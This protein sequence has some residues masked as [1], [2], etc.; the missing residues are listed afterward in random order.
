MEHERRRDDDYSPLGV[1]A[2]MYQLRSK[3]QDALLIWRRMRGE[4][5]DKL[6]TE[7]KPSPLRKGAPPF[8]PELSDDSG[9]SGSLWE[10]FPAFE[11]YVDR[12]CEEGRKLELEYDR[13]F[14]NLPSS[15]LQSEPE[16][17]CHSSY[18]ESRREIQ[19]DKPKSKSVMWADRVDTEME[20][21]IDD[22]YKTCSY[23][24][25][26][27]S[28]WH[29]EAIDTEGVEK[30]GDL[31]KEKVDCPMCTTP[32]AFKND[33]SRCISS[34]ETE[35]YGDKVV[36]SPVY[37][38]RCD[39]GDRQPN[40]Y[41]G[42]EFLPGQSD[43]YW[44]EDE[45]NSQPREKPY[46]R[47]YQPGPSQD[48]KS[49][50]QEKGGDKENNN[51]TSHTI[52]T[53]VGPSRDLGAGKQHSTI[54][55]LDTEEEFCAQ[56]L[57]SDRKFTQSTSGNMEG[58]IQQRPHQFYTSP[59]AVGRRLSQPSY[60]ESTAYSPTQLVNSS[61]QN[62]RCVHPS[63]PPF[64][65]L[66]YYT[67]EDQR[68]ISGS[69]QPGPVSKG[70]VIGQ[71]SLLECRGCRTGLC[72]IT[73][74][75]FC[76]STNQ[77]GREF[78]T[79]EPSFTENRFITPD[80]SE[81]NMMSL[82]S[83]SSSGETLPTQQEMNAGPLGL[84]IESRP[85]GPDEH[86]HPKLDVPCDQLDPGSP[87][88]CNIRDDKG[89]EVRTDQNEAAS[90]FTSPEI[91]T[92]FLPGFACD[93]DVGQ[94]SELDSR[95]FQEEITVDMSY[96]NDI[97]ASGKPGEQ[98]TKGA[99]I[100]DSEDLT[101]E[102]KAFF[103]KSHSRQK[104]VTSWT[105]MGTLFLNNVGQLAAGDP[106]LEKQEGALRE[107]FQ[108]TTRYIPGRDV[109]HVDGKLPQTMISHDKS[110]DR[111]RGWSKRDARTPANPVNSKAAYTGKRK[112][113]NK[114][115]PDKV[116]APM[117]LDASSRAVESMCTKRNTVDFPTAQDEQTP[118]NFLNTHCV[119]E[120]DPTL[121][122]PM[123][124]K[125]WTKKKRPPDLAD[126]TK[127]SVKTKT[128]E[129]VDQPVA[130]KCVN[131]SGIWSAN[132]DQKF[133]Q[134]FVLG[135]TFS[136]DLSKDQPT[137]TNEAYNG[138]NGETICGERTTKIWC[139]RFKVSGTDL[140]TKPKTLQTICQW[141]QSTEEMQ[142]LGHISGYPTAREE[143]D[144]IMDPSRC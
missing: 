10:S 85:S 64:Q 15:S 103:P 100:Q 65:P 132:S 92:G 27:K 57:R 78:R 36:G 119:D 21:S 19:T 133:E 76:T 123:K 43:M 55:K 134:H 53:Q 112:T 34:T 37:N 74:N 1:I 86:L 60:D 102:I 62:G 98:A 16:P 13:L 46:E 70:V 111:Q 48:E 120:G 136:D 14:L 45:S 2:R 113:R 12:L 58:Q 124:T 125:I 95:R 88:D 144:Q 26:T 24:P 59:G 101:D 5:G 96:L 97:E 87:Y 40:Y 44:P 39:R 82:Q 110:P 56:A 135:H 84:P 38:R 138:Q 51:N 75:S 47:N 104:E 73:D 121:P 143:K 94:E 117:A 106:G 89:L 109:A 77:D 116:H 130:G 11:K 4:F 115:P 127:Q 63:T 108:T 68:I 52:L 28:F 69:R 6:R 20:H 29:P 99:A 105:E 7:F 49:L 114:G 131:S 126:A 33:Q 30:F 81:T 9:A 17:I 91:E 142:G 32:D 71:D 83:A 41:S 129:M 107:G 122:N 42:S 66:A 35:D 80:L 93:D 79:S 50:G 31:R 25:A 3:L 128:K 139:K 90:L 61:F 8:D 137:C 140:P 118:Q 54:K 22:F 67:P 141:G 23:D 72:H 18:V